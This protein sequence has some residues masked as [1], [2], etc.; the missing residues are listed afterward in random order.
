MRLN[1]AL[2]TLLV[3]PAV[4]GVPAFFISPLPA[5]AAVN[6]PSPVVIVAAPGQPAT[7]RLVS[8]YRPRYY[9]V[10]K[11]DTLWSIARGEYG[12][13][14]WWPQLW[15]QNSKTLSHPD[16]ITAGTRLRITARWAEK[17]AIPA[18]YLAAIS[19]PKAPAPVGSGAPPSPDPA[20]QPSPAPPAPQPPSAGIY[21]YAQLEALWV[22]AGGPPSVQAAAAAIAECESGGNPHAYN[23]S[24][25]S[26]LFQILGLPFPGDP[27]DPMTNARMAVAKY[28]AAGGF[29]P[30]V[31][32]P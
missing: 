20:P 16:A 12:S 23:P 7:A 2:L 14:R 9:T 32:Q 25:A 31:C 18:T 19:K 26:G 17:P 21:S 11:G 4:A 29:S 13:G 28:N 24:G 30:W 10:R 27:F 5:Q 15:K 6:R 1:K 22:A 3:I 8:S